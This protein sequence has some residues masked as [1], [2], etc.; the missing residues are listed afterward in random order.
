M[1]ILAINGSLSARSVN[2][3]VLECAIL[4]T[5]PD[6]TISPFDRLSEIPMVDGRLADDAQ[7]PA[8]E[9]LRREVANADALLIV[10]PEYAHSMPGTLKN[11]LDWL[12]PTGELAGKRVAIIS[13]STTP[14]GGL[15]AQAALI[16]TLL[17][18]SAEIVALLPIA[19]V[20]RKLN[21]ERTL[22]HALT[23][24]RVRET[25][26]ALAAHCA[27]ASS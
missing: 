11:A 17:A 14:T 24:R 1:K 15:R 20:E 7:D 27:E 23:Q 10:T 12:V 16:H 4:M 18:Q 25:L 3:A 8:V 26:A 9:S 21:A 5:P 19:G 2:R 6:V 13:A 22:V